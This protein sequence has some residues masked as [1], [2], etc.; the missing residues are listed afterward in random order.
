MDS[1][2]EPLDS[3]YM[4]RLFQYLRG[5]VF[6]RTFS[7]NLFF[8]RVSLPEWDGRLKPRLRRLTRMTTLANSLA[9]LGMAPIRFGGRG[10]GGFI[11]MLFG[12]AIVG[13]LVWALTRPAGDQVSK[14]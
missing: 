3:R 6:P 5:S 4:H 10:P 8:E 7:G 9:L 1:I 12:L 2:I 14:N 13:A 11:W